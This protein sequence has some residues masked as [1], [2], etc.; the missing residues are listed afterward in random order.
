MVVLTSVSLPEI[1]PVSSL[2]SIGSGR[3]SLEYYQQ[4]QRGAANT[5]ADDLVTGRGVV[6]I[7]AATTLRDPETQ[8]TIG[9]VVLSQKM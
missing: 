8:P 9:R 7:R 4:E 3:R 6:R 5:F 2:A 1:A